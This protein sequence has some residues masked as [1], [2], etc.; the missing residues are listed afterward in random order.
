MAGKNNV[1]QIIVNGVNN[2]GPMFSQVG[3]QLGSLGGLLTSTTALTAGLGAATIAAGKKIASAYAADIKAA[4]E[5]QKALAEVN[6]LL[7]ATP[8][9]ITGLNRQLMDLSVNFGQVAETMA[10]AE[11][12][13]VSAGFGDIADSVEIL[14]VANKAAIGGVSDVN[15]AAKLITQTLNAYGEGADQAEKYSGI[16]FSTIKG[17][18]TTFPE[19]AQN[20]GKVTATASTAGIRFEEVA[21]AM[22]AMTKKG[23][24]TAE[25]ATALQGL[26]VAI[27]AAS[28]ESKQKLDDLGINLDNGLVPALI[29][30]DGAG[31]DSLEVLKE[32]IP[33][34]RAL[35]AAAAIGAEGAKEMKTQLDAMSGGV[36]AFN[37]AYEIMSETL[38]F[39]ADRNAAAH[40]RLKKAIGETGIEGMTIATKGAADSQNKMAKAIERNSDSLSEYTTW[41]GNVGSAVA[42]FL[43]YQGEVAVNWLSLPIY[44]KN[45]DVALDEYANTLNLFSSANLNPQNSLVLNYANWA[46]LQNQIRLASEQ[47][48]QFQQEFAAVNSS[49]EQWLKDNPYIAPAPVIPSELESMD[50]GVAEED[51]ADLL[52]DIPAVGT[53]ISDL[54]NVVDEHVAKAQRIGLVYS[55]QFAIV[56]DG[57][58]GVSN[59]VADSLGGMLSDTAQSMLHLR[60]GPIMIGRAFKQMAQGIIAELSRVIAKMIAMKALMALFD[61][62]APGSGKFVGAAFGGVG[63]HGR[64]VHNAAGGY[65]VPGSSGS[66]GDLPIILPGSP[67]M[68]RTMVAARGGEMFI[69]RERV[70]AAEKMLGRVQTSPRRASSSTDRRRPA[71]E[72]QIIRPFRTEEVVRLRD[73]LNDAEDRAARYG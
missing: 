55:A 4:G 36:E 6:T 25:A 31:G 19:L 24:D 52:V 26:I 40:E 13:V 29:A 15:T 32:M 71:A 38:A 21:A 30:V 70:N 11:Y 67:G 54:G 66:Y 59:V 14:N 1:V 2:A 9:T 3:G 37:R 61:F 22:A 7:D 23:I 51:V 53:S 62:I 8:E 17:G 63:A 68:D 57:I 20:L 42:D 69:P 56:Q 48:S 49:P 35:K 10:R 58:A 39:Q 65:S 72:L 43:S 46:E 33:N 27:G 41:L 45:A 64:R 34:V 5:F 60:E 28:G 44:I 50:L 73:S 18:V 16:L 12:N 47:M